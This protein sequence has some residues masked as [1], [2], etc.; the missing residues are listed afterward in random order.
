MRKLSLLK[1][2]KEWTDLAV[3]GLALLGKTEP[4]LARLSFMAA[5][6]GF[7][8]L[9][10][11]TENDGVDRLR[12]VKPDLV[13][14]AV[15]EAG[16]GPLGRQILRERIAPVLWVLF[17]RNISGEVIGGNPPHGVL[18]A[19]SIAVDLEP[20]V[21]VA[22]A[23]FNRETHL[24]ERALRAEKTLE[25]RK[26]VEQAKGILMDQLHLSEADAFQRMRRYAMNQRRPLAEVAQHIIVFEYLK[27]GKE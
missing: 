6:S 2:G 16:P 5:Q 17:S 8:A 19:S 23:L 4:Q 20:A 21:L 10:K 27:E 22:Q 15:D 13:L 25:E 24:L 11:F 1:A 3:P 18:A 9:G 26:L 12:T 7:P 14:E